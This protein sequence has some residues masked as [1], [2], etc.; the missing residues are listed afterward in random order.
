MDCRQHWSLQAFFGISLL[1]SHASLLLNSN[2]NW[3]TLL[4]IAFLSTTMISWPIYEYWIHSN[5]EQ[6]PNKQVLLIVSIT[7]LN[8]GLWGHQMLLK[9]ES[10]Q[11]LISDEKN[12]PSP[13]AIHGFFTLLNN[14]QG[15][16]TYGD[17]KGRQWTLH[18]M[19]TGSGFYIWKVFDHKN[20]HC[21][22]ISLSGDLLRCLP[23]KQIVWQG[24]NQ[25]TPPAELIIPTV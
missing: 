1:L 7:M 19:V 9:S 23:I 8:W 6:T 16:P 10:L 17:Q 14:A 22:E 24:S 15:I 21:F 18:E 5:I 20:N 11:L 2:V 13:P 4:W 25:E 3:P 12:L